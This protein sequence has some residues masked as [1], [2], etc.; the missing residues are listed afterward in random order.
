[1]PCQIVRWTDFKMIITYCWYI[2]LD[3]PPNTRPLLLD[4]QIGMHPPS[5]SSV[6]SPMGMKDEFHPALQKIKE[7]NA[8]SILSPDTYQTINRIRTQVVHEETSRPLRPG[9]DV[10]IT[11]L[12]TGSALPSK[13]RNGE[14]CLSQLIITVYSF[15]LV[16]FWPTLFIFLSAAISCW[17]LGRAHGVK[18]FAV[19]SSV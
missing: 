14:N 13:T 17:M 16:K 10:V 4:H 5:V 7:G 19:S 2:P 6:V 8:M 15:C 9:D 1:M 11:T 18:L 12:G 3:L